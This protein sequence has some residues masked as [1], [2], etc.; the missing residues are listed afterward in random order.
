MIT[1]TSELRFLIL[2]LLL[3]AG[4]SNGF[5]QTAAIDV[6][7][8]LDRYRDNLYALETVNGTTSARLVETLEQIADHLI[9]LDEHAE[10]YTVLDR[11]QQIIKF[12]EG[13]F[14]TS[15][16]RLI[17]KKIDSL[18]STGDWRNGRK[19][20][21]HLFWLYT[22][23]IPNPDENTVAD[24]LQASTL[25]IRG[26]IEDD[27][28][29]QSY[30]R[31]SAA[32]HSRMAFLV[33]QAIWAPHDLRQGQIIYEQLKQTH[34][35]AGSNG[36]GRGTASTRRSLAS[37]DFFV[38]GRGVIRSIYRG[39]GY[40]YLEKLRGLYLD[41]ETPD[42]EAAAMAALYRADWQVLFQQRDLAIVSYAD[43]YAELL[44]AGVPEPL[45]DELFLEP[46]LIPAPAFYTT[47]V[48][49]LASREQGEQSTLLPMQEGFIRVSFT[50]ISEMASPAG[51]H[52][53]SVSSSIANP[54][55]PLF[56]F[57]LAGV[58]EITRG[59]WPYRRR[60]TLGV[61]YDLKLTESATPIDVQS[62]TLIIK[63][64]WL[65][66]RPKLVGGIPAAVT[67]VISYL[68]VSD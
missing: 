47:V 57:T 11:A 14:T 39:N 19:L 28:D 67:G 60:S 18:I 23:K 49:A 9:A 37:D 56:S 29:Y 16:F 8:E 22:H 42:L 40:L 59:R 64:G 1:V 52:S 20:Q 46:V 3:A 34:L 4:T 31:R 6:S 12:N 30:H 36:G 35:Q 58:E 7:S 26:V 54:S 48:A 62:D 45:V 5:S 66:F 43:A 51:E 61:A 15:Q 55:I 21:D 50:D 63:L 41:R 33:A 65:H 10:A 24:L 68:A 27:P 32:R 17:R 38:R 2:P 13:L 25:H 44:A 53:S